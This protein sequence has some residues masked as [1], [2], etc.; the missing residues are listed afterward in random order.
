MIKS[1][2]FTMKINFY[3]LQYTP[4]QQIYGPETQTDHPAYVSLK[5]GGDF[6]GFFC[7]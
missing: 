3:Q 2:E 5:D 4:I 6:F 7:N 1:E